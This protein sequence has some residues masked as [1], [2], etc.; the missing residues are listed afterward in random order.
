MPI[1]SLQT[2]RAFESAGRLKSYSRAGAELGLTHSA[3]SRRMRDLE[4]MVGAQLFDRQGN[5]MVPTAE[6]RRLLAEVK[7]AIAVLEGIFPASSAEKRQRIRVSIFPG[8]ALRWLGPRMAQFH[9][10]HPTI[11]CRLDISSDVIELKGNAS[12][13]LRYGLGNWPGTH[14]RRLRDEVIF[15]VCSPAYR[16]S[17]RL[18]DFADLPHCILLRYP[19]YGWRGWLAAV[20]TKTGPLKEGPEFSD[21]SL[22]LNA[23]EAGEGVALARGLQ[24]ADALESGTLVRP[25]PHELRDDNGYYF[26]RSPGVPDP[27]L[28]AFE[29][30]IAK[31]IDR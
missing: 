6:G 21:S 2:L 17:H 16:D 12:G 19:W 24:V 31:A 25:F 13:A 27:A 23:A 8:L 14:S 11:D 5:R 15:P 1:P 22:L 9:R 20:G 29:R 7:G 3:V 10:L 30:W 26:V 18:N 4:L 28:T